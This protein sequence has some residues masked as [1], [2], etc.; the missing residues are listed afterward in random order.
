MVKKLAHWITI[1]LPIYW[2]WRKTGMWALRMPGWEKQPCPAFSPDHWEEDTTGHR[3]RQS[4]SLSANTQEGRRRGRG[5]DTCLHPEAFPCGSAATEFAYNAG[6]SA[7]NPWVGK[8]PL[9][10]ETLPAPVF[11]PGECHGLVHGVAKSRTRL[12]DFHLDFLHPDPRLCVGLCLF[13]PVEYYGSY[14]DFQACVI[15]ASQLLSY[16]FEHLSSKS[17]SQHVRILTTQRLPFSEK[18]FLHEEAT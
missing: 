13:W 7:F 1:Y 17:L 11:W 14:T 16:S 6:R 15:K 2:G 5:L 9:R 10:R 8:I 4:E 18:T 3:R 12:N